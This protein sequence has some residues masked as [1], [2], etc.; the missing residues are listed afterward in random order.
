VQ[1]PA[2]MVQYLMGL[3][4][5]PVSLNAVNPE[6]DRTPVPLSQLALPDV[7]SI[8]E[9]TSNTIELGYKGILGERV[10]LAA[11]VWWA[12]RENLVTPLTIATPFIHLDAASATQYLTQALVPFFMGAGATPEQAQQQAQ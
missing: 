4:N 1:M 3:Q 5:V 6:G 11:D 7:A 10:L 9:S 8:R 2:P 12:K